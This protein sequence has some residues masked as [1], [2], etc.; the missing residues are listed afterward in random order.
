MTSYFDNRIDEIKTMGTTNTRGATR[1]NSRPFPDLFKLDEAL[2]FTEVTNSL[3]GV[4]IPFEKKPQPEFDL[5]NTYLK[6]IGKKRLLSAH[7][8]IQCAQL[9]KAGNLQA[10]QHMIESNLRLVVKIAKRYLRSG[11]PLLDLIEEGNLGLI[12][13]VG[14]FDP[15]LGFRFSTYGAW[16]IQQN[17]ERAIMNQHRLIRLPIHIGK[18]L[19]VCLRAHRELSKELD[20]EPSLEEVAN[21]AKKSRKEVEK[22]MALNERIISIDAPCSE[23]MNRPLLEMVGQEASD[24]ALQ[25][26]EDKMRSKVQ[27]WLEQLSGKQRAVLMRRFGLNGHEST[28]LERT[29]VEIGLTRERVR[30]LQRTGLSKLKLLISEHNYWDPLKNSCN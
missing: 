1:A 2:A 21:Y 20:H 16:W 25:C 4:L 19:N 23:E 30:Q 18:Q 28:T 12:R 10:K 7:E 6:E 17:I 13:A 15:S 27:G 24:P 9:V 26:M 3:P 5:A 22:L 29:G 8:E 14:K 11:V